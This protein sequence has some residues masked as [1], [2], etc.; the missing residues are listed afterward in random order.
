MSLIKIG[1]GCIRTAQTLLTSLIKNTLCALALLPVYHKSA[2][3]SSLMHPEAQISFVR[4]AISQ[5]SEPVYSAYQ[6][7]IRLADSL[8]ASPQHAVPEFNVPGFYDDRE[9]HRA[10]AKNLQ[11]DAFSA[12]TTALAYTLSGNKKYALKAIYFLNSWAGTNKSYAQ[13]DG[14]LVISYAGPGLMIAAELLKHD[15]LWQEK[16]RIQFEHWTTE[17]YQ[18]AAHSLREN[19]NNTA[20]WARYANLLSASFLDNKDELSYLIKLIK[21]DLPEKIASDGHLIEEVKRQAKGLWYTYFSLAPLTASMWCIYQATGENLFISAEQGTSIRQAISYLFYYS[22]HPSEWPWYNNPDVANP[23]TAT[24]FWPPNLLEAMRNIYPG[25]SYENYLS[26]Y[27]PITY[28]KHHFAWTF[29][30]LMP[31]LLDYQQKL[32]P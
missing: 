4:K 9:A 19:H 3:Q 23:G 7:L 28:S 11:S 25:Q 8:M 6:Q 21:H 31:I 29:P 14:P 15:R 10:M 24:G 12:Y 27:R 32:I 17:V 13:L 2:A 18:K 30:T 22:Q 1:M 20:D 16:D 26:A 5:K